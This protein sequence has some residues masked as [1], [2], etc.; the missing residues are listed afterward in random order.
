[1]KGK[2][3]KVEVEFTDGYEKRFT[4]ACLKQISKRSKAGSYPEDADK[5]KTA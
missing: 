2:E 3:I 4:E 1:M 5:K